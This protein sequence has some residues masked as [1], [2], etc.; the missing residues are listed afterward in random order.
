MNA[1]VSLRTRG[2]VLESRVVVVV[3]QLALNGPKNQ[4]C[5]SNRNYPTDATLRHRPWIHLSRLLT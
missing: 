3:T 5:P 2:N 1:N 4:S